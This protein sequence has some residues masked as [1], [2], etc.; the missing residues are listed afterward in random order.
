MALNDINLR[1]PLDSD[2]FDPSG[3]MRNLASS[4][5]GATVVPV[6][7]TTA[8][9]AL[10]TGLGWT[11]T[12][13]RPLYV[14]RADAGTGRELEVTT[15]GSAWRSIRARDPISP[16]A[17][18]WAT[19]SGTANFKVYSSSGLPQQPNIVRDGNTVTISGMIS[20]NTAAVAS[21]VSTTS[22]STIVNS[23]VIPAA[24]CPPADY[25]VVCQGS[26][27]NTWNLTI[28]SIGALAAT[29]YTGTAST[30]TWMP[31]IITYAVRD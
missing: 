16:T 22:G 4:L 15:N 1:V 12:P 28:T 6:P 13:G 30:T 3:D 9:A 20:P 17:L 8:R 29:R 14:H 25:V 31:F 27:L 24:S 7:N 19:T 18:A 5:G 10:V 21:A 26:G 2:T 23:G 11:P